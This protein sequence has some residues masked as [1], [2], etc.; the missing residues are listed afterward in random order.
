MPILPLVKITKCILWSL[1][2][3]RQLTSTKYYWQ[4]HLKT[5]SLSCVSN[6]I[7]FSIHIGNSS[8]QSS[9][10][11]TTMGK[12]WRPCFFCSLWNL[13]RSSHTETQLLSFSRTDMKVNL[14]PNSAGSVASKIFGLL[15]VLHPILFLVNL[16]ECAHTLFFAVYLKHVVLS[17]CE[18]SGSKQQSRKLHNFQHIQL[19]VRLQR[20]RCI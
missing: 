20:G 13:L 7:A 1:L 16:D 19:V 9:G 2:H 10:E 14:L 3:A 18:G 8:S 6:A 15:F 4:F 5:I 11:F 12:L 17:I